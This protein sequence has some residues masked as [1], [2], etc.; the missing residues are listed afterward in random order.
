MRWIAWA[1]F[2]RAGWLGLALFL[3]IALYG[4]YRDPIADAWITSRY[5]G[6]CIGLAIA[7]LM[8]NRK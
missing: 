8:F 5:T 7:V 4:Q 3:V 1:I 6:A 2:K